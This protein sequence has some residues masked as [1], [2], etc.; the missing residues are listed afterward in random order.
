MSGGSFDYVQFRVDDAIE[1]IERRLRDNGKTV[2]QKFEERSDEEK[3]YLS[4]YEMPW[5]FN[6]HPYWV[7]ED[8]ERAADKALGLRK[9]DFNQMTDVSKDKW[10]EVR[11]NK[12]KEIVEEH[13]N[14]VEGESFSDKTVDKITE[15]LNIVKVA[16]IYLQRIDWLFAGD[17]GEDNFLERTEEDLKEAGLAQPVFPKQ[18]FPTN[19]D[20]K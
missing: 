20:N 1:E 10:N 16:R 17:D 18:P 3:R 11:R 14:S 9:G 4:I 15:M 13:N 5:S 2:T 19:E 12:I 8:A 6:D 7:D